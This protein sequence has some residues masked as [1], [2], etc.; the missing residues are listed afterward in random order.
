MRYGDL[1]TGFGRLCRV[2]ADPVKL[3]VTFMGGAADGAVPR[4][5]AAVV[6]RALL[7]RLGSAARGRPGLGIVAMDFPESEPGLVRALVDL[8]R[9]GDIAEAEEA[10]VRGA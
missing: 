5:A 9:T 8:N 10:P 6:N 1:G 3:A 2:R 4:E 7:A